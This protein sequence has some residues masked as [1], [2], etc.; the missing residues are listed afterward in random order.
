MGEP[1]RAEIDVLSSRDEA[2]DLTPRLASPDAYPRADFQYNPALNG[3]SLA[4]RQHPNGRNFIEVVSSRP[5]NEPFIYLLVELESSTTRLMRG[6]TALLDPPGYGPPRV[7]S[8]AE[9]LSAVMPAVPRAP[10]AKAAAAGSAAVEQ[11]IQ[12]LEE[13][14]NAGAKALAGMLDRV[15]ATELAI[16]QLQ[17]QLETQGAG[18]AAPKPAAEAPP[19]RHPAAAKEAP[20]AATPPTAAVPVRP[21]AAALSQATHEQPAARNDPIPPR[22]RKSNYFNEALLAL[23]SGA[24]IM[25]VWLGYIMWGRRAPAKESPPVKGS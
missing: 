2:V 21:A 14:L 24:L 11:Q 4:L 8:A 25:V 22:T 16:R 3:A 13:Q 18:A 6:Y 12:R 17:R 10:A 1:L 23:A 5:V 7:A 9:S 19:A 15:A 20:I